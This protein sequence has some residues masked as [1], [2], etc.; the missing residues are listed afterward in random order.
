MAFT[1]YILLIA[2]VLILCIAFSKLLFK[3][4]IPSLLIFAILGM[5]FGSDG[6]GGLWF[7][8]YSFAEN[9]CEVGL[10]VIMFFGGFSTNWKTARKVAAPSLLLS[11]VGVIAT[12]ALVGVFCRYVLQMPLLESFLVGSVL[13]STDAASVFSILRSRKLNLKTGLAPLLEVESGSN[14]PCSYMITALLLSLMGT[15]QQE[16]IPLLIAEQIGFGLLLG[17]G[18]GLLSERVLAHIHF[19]VMGLYPILVAGIALLSYALTETLHGNAYLA[20]YLTGILLGNGRT[21]RKRSLL[22][23]FDSMSWVMQIFMFFTLGLLCFPSRLFQ[24]FGI[25][26]AIF[27][28]LTFVAR[29]A[30]VFAILSFFHYSPKSMAFVSWVGLRGAASI[31]FAIFAVTHGTAVQNDIYHIVF[32]VSMFSVTIQGTFLPLIANKLDLIDDTHVNV[33]QTFSDYG[34]EITAN[35]KRVHIDAQ[36]PWA[37]KSVA[38]AGIPDDILLVLIQRGKE[39]LVPNGSTEILPGDVLILSGSDFDEV[40]GIRLE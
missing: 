30:V 7:D 22:R 19:E 13:S 37:H 1:S 23:F 39:E 38:E 24:V 11:T 27:L 21:P 2:L 6:I 17:V 20:V 12:T 29:P 26:L 35:L 4:G 8:N 18:I 36:Y 5:L 14:D 40:P 34:E 28:F 10:A 16:N 33:L 31:V 32:F 3:F 25:S 9:L 15:S